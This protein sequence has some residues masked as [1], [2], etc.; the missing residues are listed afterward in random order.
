MTDLENLRKRVSKIKDLS[1]D[2]P[3]GP[4]EIFPLID[5]LMRE[6]ERNQAQQ[7][8]M[9]EEY[10]EE[11]SKTYQEISTLFE[12]NNLFSSVID[13]REKLEEMSELLLQ[14][15]SFCGIVIDLK[16]PDQEIHFEQKIDVSDEIFQ[17][18]KYLVSNLEEK[19]LL[20]EPSDRDPL[21]SNLLSVPVKSMKSIWGRITLVEKKNGI[22]TA[23]DRKILEAAAQQLAAVCERNLRL[24]QEVERERLKREL[25]IA[26]QIQK[27]LLPVDPPKI[28]FAELKAYSEPAVQVGGDYYDF[29]VRGEKLM[30]CVADVSGKGIPAALLMTSFRSALRTLA[31]APKNI[32]ELASQLNSI[33]CEDLEEDRFVTGVFCCFNKAGEVEIVNAGH[34][35]VLIYRSGKVEVI[36]AHDLPLGIVSNF[37]YQS[38][39]V[40]L[41]PGDVILLY[42]D[43]VIEAKNASGEEYGLERLIE[44]FQ[45]SV[46]FPAERIAKE[47]EKD[48]LRFVG[49]CPQHDDTTIVVVK[50]L[51]EKS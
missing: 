5:D 4:N 9:M 51:G 31:A 37:V 29:M 49:D 17:H 46:N 8:K 19:V 32:S 10:L 43:G 36:N 12:L 1:K 34:N 14:T 15:I 21:I 13:P 25:E 20:L 35:P 22:Y 6:I 45:S 11:L 39:R 44:V 23:A 28:P 41:R 16:L 38:E 18:A 24:R 3:I 30:V 42:T 40:S 27:R 7:M 33:F 50:Y 48:L 47:I 2:K 26:R